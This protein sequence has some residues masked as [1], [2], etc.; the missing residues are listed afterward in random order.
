MIKN[1]IS[2]CSQ[3]E[4]N[5]YSLHVGISAYNLEI[6]HLVTHAFLKVH[7]CYHEQNK[8]GRAISQPILL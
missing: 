7:V 5:I 2:T 4:S 6:F 3:F 1:Y 8:N